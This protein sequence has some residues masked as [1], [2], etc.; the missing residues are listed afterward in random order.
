ME[1]LRFNAAVTLVGGG[2]VTA[3]A[4]ARARALAPHLVAAD[5]GADALTALGLV[6]EA[7]IGDLDSLRDPA[8]W[9][10]PTRVV[11]LAEQDTT[12]FEKCLYATRAPLY[13]GVGFTGGRVDHLLATLSTMLRQGDRR[14]VLLD[15]GEAMA[16]APPGR[17]LTL[18]L[19]PGSVV[20]IYP[21]IPVRAAWARGLDWPIEGLDLAP[22][23]RISTSNATAAGR[24][25]LEFQGPGALVVVESAGLAALIRALG[26]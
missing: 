15:D 16:V 6:P 2:P 11:H 19:R 21:L 23:G 1:P 7:I 22:G 9:G 14:V 13:L 18:D 12:D 10:P 24:V 5:G 26:P 3:P 20:S 17:R 4:V 25:E 8:A